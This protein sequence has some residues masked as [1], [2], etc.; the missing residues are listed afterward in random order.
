MFDLQEAFQD[1]NIQKEDI[2][3]I[4]KEYLPEFEHIEKG[5][6]LDSKM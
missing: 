6:S 1:S 4:L 5:L 3:H 2:V